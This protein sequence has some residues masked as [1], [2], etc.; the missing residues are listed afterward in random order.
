MTTRF[1]TWPVWAARLLLALMAAL[2]VWGGL[3]TPVSQ[4]VKPGPPRGSNELLYRAVTER[5]ERGENYYAAASA[6]QRARYFPTSPAQTFREPALAWLLA[7]LKTDRA[8]WLAMLGLSLATLVALGNALART[9]IDARLRWFAIPLTA[10]GLAITWF[11]GS[12][13]LHEVWAGLLIALSLALY[14]PGRWV[15]PLLIGLAACF[16]RELALPYLAAMAA[17]ALVERRYREFAGWA[18]GIAIFGGFFAWHIA[19]ARTLHEPGDLTRAGWIYFGGWPFVLETAR[20]NILLIFAPNVVVAALVCVS[21]LGLAGPRNP[22]VSRAAVIAG[23]YM[24]SFSIAGWPG[25]T[26]WG[27]GNAYWGLLYAPLLPLG[28]AL[29]PLSLRDLALRAWGARCASAPLP[30]HGQVTG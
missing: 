27:P 9:G 4:L 28:V 13:W 18:V 2:V 20:Q 19:V 21:L 17:F 10:S 8:R 7:A 23:G 12:A 15:L 14:R 11:P 22:W 3:V 24:V 30:A 5:V 25:N 29:A 6:E 1:A 26:I 16:I